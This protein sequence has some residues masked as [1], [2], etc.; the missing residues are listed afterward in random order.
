MSGAFFCSICFEAGSNSAYFFQVND[1]CDPVTSPTL[2]CIFHF[3]PKCSKELCFLIDLTLHKWKSEVDTSPPGRPLFQTFPSTYSQTNI[4]I[5]Y[6]SQEVYVS[7]LLQW[8]YYYTYPHLYRPKFLKKYI[9]KS[10]PLPKVRLD[11]V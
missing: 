8:I 4:R 2:L 1:M 9:W 5:E 3:R 6:T 11:G 7:K 10:C